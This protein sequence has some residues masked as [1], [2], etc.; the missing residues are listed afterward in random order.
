MDLRCINRKTMSENAMFVPK[1]KHHYGTLV[2]PLSFLKI[3]TKK[4][5]L[6]WQNIEKAKKIIRRDDY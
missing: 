4:T 1:P 2:Q 3:Q 5:P 6:I